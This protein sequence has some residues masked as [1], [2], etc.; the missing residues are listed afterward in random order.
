M[1][2]PRFSLCIRILF[3]LLAVAVCTSTALA[4]VSFEAAKQYSA[5]VSPQA[6]AIGDLNHDGWA[7]LVVANRGTAQGNGGSISV[8]LNMGDGTFQRGLNYDRGGIFNSV[9]IADFNHDRRLDVAT[10][11]QATGAVD[12]MLGN[13]DGTLQSPVSYAANATELLKFVTVGDINGDSRLDLIVADGCTASPCTASDM[14]VLVGNGDGTFDPMVS[15]STS[16]KNIFSPVIVD[17]NNDGKMD[18]VAGT[19]SGIAIFAGHGDGTFAPALFQNAVVAYISLA[20]GE[21][22]SNTNADLAVVNAGQPQGNPGG[23]GVLL[24]NGTGKF[25]GHPV[26]A[27]KHP[28]FVGAADIDGDGHMDLVIKGGADNNVYVLTG[29]GDGT[30][31]IAQPFNVNSTFGTFAIGDLDNDGHLDLV[32]TD[33]KSTVQVLINA[34]P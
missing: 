27:I 6:V 33:G 34:A 25:T 18:V 23:A 17:V 9:V 30:F 2:V 24:G 4:T 5:G 32:A 19:D 11:N 15:Y 31:S 28:S 14:G 20:A 10:T 16:L 3:I 12:I 26:G 21:F 29:I 13:G 8:L 22:D 1:Q 7:D